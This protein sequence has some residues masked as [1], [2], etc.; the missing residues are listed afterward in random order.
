MSSKILVDELAGKTTAKD[1]TVTVGASVTMSLEKGV[2]KA[3]LHYDQ[4]TNNN[5][6]SLSISSVADT[7][8]G[9]WTGTLSNPM[10]DVY[11]VISG[12]SSYDAN[13]VDAPRADDQSAFPQSTTVFQV[14]TFNNVNTH[15][16]NIYNMISIHGDLA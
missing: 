14:S 11:Y 8:A 3:W 1:I 2:A 4:A 6:N 13:V 10:A 7:A 9:H 15:Y 12:A 16:D 5:R